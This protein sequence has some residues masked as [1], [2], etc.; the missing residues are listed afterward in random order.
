MAL[1]LSYPTLGPGVVSASEINSNFTTISAK[2]GNIDNSDIKAGAGISI[3]KLSASYEYMSIGFT[4]AGGSASND[5]LHPLYNDG[6]GDWTAVGA[7]WATI[8][9][10]DPSAVVTIAWGVL[11]GSATTSIASD[12]TNVTTVCTMALTG[13]NIASQGATSS[14]TSFAF[15]GAGVHRSLRCYVSTTDADA[16]SPIYVSLLLKRQIKT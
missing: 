4:L 1:T 5:V 9:T 2:F 12:W 10:G 14:V 13:A 16:T 15:G 3:D 11:D 6:K 7:Q 8:D